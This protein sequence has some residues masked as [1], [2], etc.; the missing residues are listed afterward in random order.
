MKSIGW[1]GPAKIEYI[2][3]G[4]G[5]TLLLE[6]NPRFWMPLN[7]AIKPCADF[8]LLY[9][10][11][12]IFLLLLTSFTL[13]SAN[14]STIEKNGEIITVKQ[15]DGSI[16][17]T[18]NDDVAAIENAIQTIGTGT[19]F[20][21]KGVYNID[22]SIALKS[23]LSFVG[24]DGVVFKCFN[25]VAFNT[26]SDGYSSSTISLTRSVSSHDADIELSSTTGLRVNDYVKISDDLIIGRYKNGEIAKIISINGNT[27]TVDRPLYDSYTTSRNAMIREISMFENI[28]FDKIKFVG[29]GMETK[30]VAIRLYGARNIKIS[31]SEF[32][33]F[34]VR[35]L[36][37]TDSLD[38]V[39]ENNTFRRIFY[40]GMGYS[41][42]MANACDNITIRNNSFL[43][44]GRHYIATG[45]RTGTR[46][47]GGLIRKV[48]VL[49]NIFEDSTDEAVNTHQASRAIFEV[50]GNRFT[51]CVKGVEFSNTDSVISN[52]DFINCGSKCIQIGGEG[53]HTIKGNYFENNQIRAVSIEDEVESIIED[54][55]FNNGGY[56][57]TG[58][59]NSI[60]RRNRF[61]NYGSPALYLA[62]T[63]DAN[64]ENITISN[65]VMESG[66]TIKIVY[67]KDFNFTGNKI[68]SS[69]QLQNCDNVKIDYNNIVSEG[70]GLR[71]LDARGK[72]TIVSNEIDAS[73][74]GISLENANGN[75]IA[76]EISIKYTNV[77]APTPIYNGGYSNV[78]IEGPLTG[79]P[80]V[81]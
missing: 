43:E 31:N 53:F 78:I 2:L 5:E 12:I 64:V 25:G 29:F 63:V 73:S 13:P 65:N 71:I 44:K 67:C 61:I 69:V 46:I 6:V 77:N 32:T 17:Y 18:G 4:M 62:G 80:V 72:H 60:I 24:E 50:S 68:N 9:I 20:F 30:S 57:N 40:D 33:D 54:N 11:V 58:P 27:I 47:S 45:G 7:L 49:N 1:K 56:I 66:A 76:H 26:G 23:N 21:K 59:G 48:Y 34:G 19:I 42:S 8:L 51:N 22:S 55:T 15:D 52:N 14:T 10:L 79:N 39:I 81:E 3:D 36:D 75:P 16:T 70:N 41:V 37:F 74:R 28:V 38:T 35:A